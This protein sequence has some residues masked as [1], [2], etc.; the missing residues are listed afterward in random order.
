[1]QNFVGA[2][3]DGSVQP[4]LLGVESAHAL[5]DGDLS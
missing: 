5:V 4:V 3:N 2:E 1:M